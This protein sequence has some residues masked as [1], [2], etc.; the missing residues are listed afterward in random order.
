[1]KLFEKLKILRKS[2]KYTQKELS[3]LLEVGEVTYQKYEYGTMLPNYKIIQ[4]LCNQFPQYTLWLMTDDITAKQT[5]PT[6]ED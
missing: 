1:M 6:Y 4:K 3:V 5:E 2:I